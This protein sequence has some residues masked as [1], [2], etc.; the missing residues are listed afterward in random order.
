MK[1]SSAEIDLENGYKICNGKCG[2]KK[3]L[4]EFS[5]IKKIKWFRGQCK[6][7]RRN[8]MKAWRVDNR[9]KYLTTARKSI[10]RNRDKIRIRDR[11]RYKRLKSNPKYAI[12]KRMRGAVSYT[13]KGRK[14]RQSWK[15]MVD[16]SPEEL[17][18]HII[19]LFAKGMT[20]E[21]FVNGEIE[22]DHK[23]PS[24]LF[25]FTDC[26]DKQFKACW[27]LQNLQPLW[28]QEN[29]IKN[30]RLH[31]GRLVRNLSNEEKLE[32]IKKFVSWY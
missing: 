17:L 5:F 1:K 14:N 11:E 29:F 3:D 27:N 7:C 18:N 16:Y 20:L 10:E 21:S 25:T 23:F 31:D 22:I 24:S 13:L 30:D 28:K 9:D 19:S 32:Y 4:S 12:N 15:T 8:T 26:N 2:E 6:S